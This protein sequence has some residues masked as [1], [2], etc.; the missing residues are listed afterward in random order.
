M[1]DKRLLFT[2][3]V[4]DVAGNPR[5][6]FSLD[7]VVGHDDP[8]L[9]SLARIIIVVNPT[10]SAT[11][12]DCGICMMAGLLQAGYAHLLLQRQC[13]HGQEHLDAMADYFDEHRECLLN[14]S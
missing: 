7:N 14:H 11:I 6:D 5:L 3:Y 10:E 1:T 8:K 9:E 12:G 13:P 2:F 4:H